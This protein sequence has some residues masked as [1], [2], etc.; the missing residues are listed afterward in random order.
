MAN[1]ARRARLKWVTS[2]IQMQFGSQ[3]THSGHGADTAG[4]RRAGSG[5]L[6][7]CFSVTRRN[8]EGDTNTLPR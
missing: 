5:S 8:V 1:T 2:Q 3:R 7:W 6:T 4:L